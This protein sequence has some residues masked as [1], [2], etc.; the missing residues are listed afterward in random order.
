MIE[1]IIE[2]QNLD[3]ALRQMERSDAIRVL[4]AHIST[5]LPG[6]RVDGMRMSVMVKAESPAEAR[7]L[8]ES[9]LPPDESISVRPALGYGLRSVSPR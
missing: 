1:F 7:K 4:G 8:V 6:A 2:G 9:Y 3:P 5:R